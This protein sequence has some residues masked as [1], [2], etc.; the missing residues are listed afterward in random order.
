[1]AW[2]T[3]DDIP[4]YRN[5]SC[6]VYYEDT[7]K[8]IVSYLKTFEDSDTAHKFKES[9]EDKKGKG[10]ISYVDMNFFPTDEG[11]R[12]FLDIHKDAIKPT[13]RLN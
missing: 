12:L 2:W 13:T 1:M 3:D 5:N 10:Y 8:G 11:I 9:L 7:G 4:F 6:V